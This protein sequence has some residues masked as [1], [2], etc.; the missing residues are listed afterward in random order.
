MHAID[1][2][3]RTLTELDFARL[4]KAVT[5][6]NQPALAA[7]L[8]NADVIPSTEVRADVVTMSSRVELRDLSTLR[9]QVLTVCH[10]REAVP[11]AGLISV[12]S[13]VG[14]ALIGLKAG[15]IAR[16][17]TPTGDACAAEITAVHYQPEA[18]GDWVL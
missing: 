14:Q 6:A 2:G 18:A 8:A 11:S 17:Q 1:T 4:T 9:R 5:P 12:L 15:D 16:W 13:P 3:E 7:I 10:A